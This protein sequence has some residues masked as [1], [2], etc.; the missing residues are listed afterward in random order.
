MSAAS[1]LALYVLPRIFTT[2]LLL[3]EAYLPR[4]KIEFCDHANAELSLSGHGFQLRPKHVRQLFENNDLVIQSSNTLFQSL[5]LWPSYG[6]KYPVLSPKM[7]KEP[8]P[9]TPLRQDI[10]LLSPG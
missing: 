8:A 10:P 4:P 1:P 5:N 9:S 7:G 6:K 2:Q 3:Q